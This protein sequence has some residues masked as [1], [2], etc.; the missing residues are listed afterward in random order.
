MEDPEAESK[1]ILLPSPVEEGAT[2]A[3]QFLTANY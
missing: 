2:I 3:D 1:T